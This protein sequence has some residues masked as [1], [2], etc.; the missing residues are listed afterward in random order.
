MTP[1]ETRRQELAREYEAVPSAQAFI[2]VCN[3]LIVAERISQARAALIT[4][5]EEE[6]ALCR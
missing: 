5:L 3:R 2:A 1:D 4:L 6:N